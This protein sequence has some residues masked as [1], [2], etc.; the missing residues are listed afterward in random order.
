MTGYVDHEITFGITLDAQ[1]A[2]ELALALGNERAG[3][4]GQK[5]YST[6][7]TLLRQEAEAGNVDLALI[8]R[9]EAWLE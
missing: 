8:N 5:V 3:T 2:V 9:L 1:D 6:L 7:T 4:A